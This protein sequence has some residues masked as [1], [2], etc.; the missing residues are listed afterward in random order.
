MAQVGKDGELE[1]EEPRDLF[2]EENFQNFGCTWEEKRETAFF[3][4]SHR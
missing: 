3:R 2:T 4:Y 1:M